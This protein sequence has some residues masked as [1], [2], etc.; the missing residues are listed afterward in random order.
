M[1]VVFY[2]ILPGNNAMCLPLD[3]DVIVE[4]P[5]AVIQKLKHFE[6]LTGYKQTHDELRKFK[7]D[8]IKMSAKI[9][10]VK[11]M[12]SNDPIKRKF[13]N[14]D[15]LAQESHSSATTT[16]FMKATGNRMTRLKGSPVQS[17]EFYFHEKML[18]SGLMTLNPKYKGVATDCY[19]Y[20]FSRYY[21][22]L[23]IDKELKFPLQEG[24][25]KRYIS[26]NFTKLQ[27]GIYR[28]KIDCEN[29]R[30]RSMFNFSPDNY[31]D[32][33]TLMYVYSIKD[34]YDVSMELVRD[35]K[36]PNAYVY[37]KYATGYDHFYTWY[38]RLEQLRYE[39]EDNQLVKIMMSTLWGRLTGFKYELLSSDE[40]Q[41]YDITHRH[42]KEESEYKI[43][44]TVNGTDMDKQT[45]RCINTNDPFK[46]PYGRLKSFL[47]SF[48]RLQMLK[49]IHE[50]DLPEVVRIHTDGI[51]LS[52]PFDMKSTSSLWND[53]VH[54]T[55]F[56][57]A[58][59][60]ITGKITF[61]NVLRSCRDE[62][63]TEES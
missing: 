12:T 55:Y 58:D 33:E 34:D 31:Y 53:K 20:D 59:K 21:V 49:L 9:K 6:M 37:E 44:D 5:Y 18:K 52:K 2:Y 54:Q 25:P 17:D 56:P 1:Q 46:T 14:L 3:N 11:L 32:S 40:I 50:Y 36:K 28:V 45:Y 7:Q 47:T 42:S 43:V 30:F 35:K 29:S 57:K 8:M 15:Y 13:Y 19:G 61:F 60:K 4:E 41:N 26:V 10:R 23:M 38:Y 39:C 48:G 24:V 22:H 16:Q 63:V 51:I 62:S 27:F